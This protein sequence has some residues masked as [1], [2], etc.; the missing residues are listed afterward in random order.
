MDQSTA[1]SELSQIV[2][3]K[4]VDTVKWIRFNRPEI[5]NAVNT[6]SADLLKEELEKSVDEKM[7]VVVI[8][9]KGGSFCAGADLKA[10]GGN[11]DDIDAMS[12]VLTEHYHPMLR[13]L[14]SLPIP[15]IAA[16]DGI[17]AGI[18]ADI[19]LACDIRLASETAVFSEIFSQVGL[20]PDGGGTYTLPR[21]V[22]LGRAL[23]MAL[24]GRMVKADQA[25]EWGIVSQ[26]FPADRFV[27][28]VQ[29]YADRLA[30]RAP[31]ALSR[32]K[33]AIRAAAGA[34]TFDEAILQEAALQ[35]D[36]FASRD[37][38][39]GVSAF[40]QKRSPNFQGR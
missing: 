27:Q 22:G 19:A 28:Q 23:E 3:T 24:T 39:E 8:T 35:K 32:T 37:F 9:G 17:A 25:L 33:Q 26:V 18:G 5:K 29:S 38:R 40:V 10:V 6:Q 31:M 7:R 4:V 12:A 20:L 34:M 15:V 36:L 2:T 21:I 16:V 11:F 1:A 30:A 13:T 14:N